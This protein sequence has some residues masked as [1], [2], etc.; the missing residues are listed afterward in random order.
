M[1]RFAVWGE[2]IGIHVV[3]KNMKLDIEGENGT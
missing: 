3:K 2:N 1:T